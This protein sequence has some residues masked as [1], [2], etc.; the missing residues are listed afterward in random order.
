MVLSKEILTDNIGSWIFSHRGELLGVMEALLA[1]LDGETPAYIILK[2]QAPDANKEAPDRYY[3][4]SVHPAQVGFNY[5]GSLSLQI[6]KEVLPKLLGVMADGL[7]SAAPDYP[8]AV[9][10]YRYEELTAL[11]TQNPE[12]NQ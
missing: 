7:P 1:G 9:E 12:H 8:T 4:I 11:E 10:L 5:R 3:A 6:D 2:Y